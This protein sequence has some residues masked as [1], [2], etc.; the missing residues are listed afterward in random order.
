MQKWCWRKK[1]SQNTIGLEEVIGVDDF[2][3]NAF[4][5]KKVSLQTSFSSSSL[6]TAINI[7]EDTLFLPLPF[8]NWMSAQEEEEEGEEKEEEEEEEEQIE[9]FIN[10]GLGRNPFFLSFLLR[11]L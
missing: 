7:G 4:F 5:M 9:R 2:S 10:T 8:L 11:N 3:T 6:S 1:K